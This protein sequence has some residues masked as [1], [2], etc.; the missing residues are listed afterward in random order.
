MKILKNMNKKLNLL[1]AVLV[2][3]ST[4]A[5]T[6][7]GDDTVVVF[8]GRTVFGVVP[9]GV[10]YAAEGTRGSSGLLYVV[11]PTTETIAVVGPIGYA[12]GAMAVSPDGR[13]FGLTNDSRWSDDTEGDDL[14]YLVEINPATGEA[15]IIGATQFEGTNYG[16]WAGATFIGDTLYAVTANRNSNGGD[17]DEL[18]KVDLVTGQVTP[19]ET[20]EPGS[21]GNGLAYDAENEELL[22]AADGSDGDLEIVDPMDGST[23]TKATMDDTVDE[24][25]NAMTFVGN[26][27][28]GV[29]GSYSRLGSYLVEIDPSDGSLDFIYRI[30]GGI[31]AIAAR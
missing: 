5:V 7:C 30:P 3:A 20:N 1:L 4:I 9:A 14:E 12:I 22:I 17:E 8:T 24:P 19:T 27:L 13:L 25:M 6:S 21:Y 15:R 10:I 11:N 18:V 26:R 23:T 16:P 2:A 31:D 29:R 28:I